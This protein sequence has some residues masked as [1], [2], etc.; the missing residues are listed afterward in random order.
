MENPTLRQRLLRLRYWLIPADSR[1]EQFYHTLRLTW[2]VAGTAGKGKFVQHFPAWKRIFIDSQPAAPTPRQGKRAYAHWIRRHEPGKSE[3]E[4]QRSN[5]AGFQYRPLI[6]IL[7]TVDNPDTAALSDTFRSVQAQTYPAWELCLVMGRDQS[8]RV[9][10]T[11]DRFSTDDPRIQV[12]QLSQNACT[13]DNWNQALENAHGE[14]VLLLQPGD[15]LS[16]A[17]LYAVVKQLDQDAGADVVYFDQDRLGSDGRRHS[18]WFKPSALSPDLLLSTNYLGHAAMQR[19]LLHEVGAFDP[20]MAGTE[21]WDLALRL[22]ET[23]GHIR[24]IPE[25][26]VHQRQEMVT[27]ETHSSAGQLAAQKQAIEAHL[28]RLGY[29]QARV[30]RS[31]QKLVHVHWPVSRKKISI[32]IPTKDK[33]QLLQACLESIFEQTSYPDYE[34]VLVDTGSQEP[35][36]QEYYRELEVRP[37]LRLLTVPGPFNYHRV[38]NLGAR[39][40]AGEVLVFL[41]NDTQ[42]LD[43]T[44]L[45][46]LVGWAE[47]PEAGIVGAQLIRPDGTLQHAGLVIGL[48]GH[49]SHVFDG[50][51][52]HQDG[53]FGSSDWYRDYQAVTGAC[54]AVRREVFEELGGF[55]EAYQ[56]GYG[57]IDL[58]LRAV[59]AGYQVIYNPFA[60]LLHHEGATRGLA[61]PP[62]DVLRASV[63]MHPRIQAGDPYFSPNLSRHSRLPAIA[64]PGETPASASVASILRIL[65]AYDLIGNHDLEAVDPQ[66][67]QVQLPLP[68][69]KS[70]PQT[71]LLV[72]THELSRSGAPIVLWKLCRSLAGQGYQVTVLSP[73][74][75]PLQAAYQSDGITVHIIPSLLSDARM[76]LPYLQGQDLVLANTILSYRTVHAAKAANIPVLFWVHESELGQQLCRRSPAAAAAIRQAEQV[77]F[78]S[79]ATAAL[80]REFASANPF[81]TIHIGIEAAQPNQKRSVGSS[82]PAGLAADKFNLVVVGSVEPRKGQDILLQALELL[83]AEVFARVEC[84]LIGRILMKQNKK[85]CQRLVKKAN[86]LG[87]VHLLGEMPP[88]QVKQYLSAADVFILPSRDEALPQSILEAMAYGKAIIASNVGGISEILQDEVNGLLVEK[89]Y[90]A[91]LADAIHRLYLDE[92]TRYNLGGAARRTFQNSLTF[93]RF[94]AQFQTLIQDVLE[95]VQ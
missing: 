78:P 34:I 9:K 32:I 39:Q 16:P 10:Q 57:D 30:D 2:Q 8:T 51:P 89:E 18:P 67:W 13:G 86:R 21:A 33:L 93:D 44:W 58:C 38:C 36:T 76:V 1:R 25:V 35:A 73:S 37:N 7:I 28:T 65:R 42:A 81:T 62:G 53:P 41:N 11:L 80:Y 17:A 43:P 49:G 92:N 79:N 12:T 91:S 88:E 20:A 61:Q 26:L 48:G 70:D 27:S 14:Y 55:D 90:P 19:S 45:E 59:D 50:G 29:P 71:R 94:M 4:L 82:A 6:S 47:R 5:Q 74:D 60:R 54:L 46:E 40:A 64:Q 52:E 66:R 77:I 22:V 83:P 23:T 72:I 95:T 24:H 69:S 56:V 84:F 15:R 31:A 87:N 3:L 63:R 75:G 68:V 85:Y